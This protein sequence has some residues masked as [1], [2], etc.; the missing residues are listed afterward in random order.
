[1]RNHIRFGLKNALKTEN[2]VQIGKNRHSIR[3]NVYP[4]S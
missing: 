3:T 2:Y 4:G 1:M